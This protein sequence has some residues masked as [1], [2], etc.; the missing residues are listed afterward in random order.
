MKGEST[1]R[2]KLGK[3]LECAQARPTTDRCRRTLGER[4]TSTRQL[5]NPQHE[6]THKSPV[7]TRMGL[8]GT[9]GQ[10]CLALERLVERG[11]RTGHSRAHLPC[12]GKPS[13]RTDSQKPWNDSNE[14]TAQGTRGHTCL[15]LENPQ[16]EL[17]HKSPGMTRRM[18]LP[19]RTLEATLALNSHESLS[20]SSG[21]KESF[22]LDVRAD[23]KEVAAH[24]RHSSGACG[25]GRAAD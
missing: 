6:L 4:E 24:S 1:W 18:R 25:R 14:A 22:T 2:P 7:T 12:P 10:T 16:H 5:E 3:T 23:S 20:C 21:S 11:Y 17:T 13:T 9:R 8:R 15:A 19:Y